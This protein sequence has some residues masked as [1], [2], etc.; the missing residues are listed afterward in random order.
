VKHAAA[1]VNRSVDSEFIHHRETLKN[2][3][4]LCFFSLSSFPFSD[5]KAKQ[6]Q[7]LIVSIEDPKKESYTKQRDHIQQYSIQQYRET[8]S[9]ETATT[10]C[11][12]STR[13]GKYL[14]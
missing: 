5:E 12:H 2:G 10:P 13:Q 8:K 9:N 14:N 7:T 3:G 11:S 1:I 6:T 4:S